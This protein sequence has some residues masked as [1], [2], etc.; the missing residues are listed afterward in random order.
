MSE[1]N[2]TEELP[3]GYFP[4]DLKLIQKHQ[5]LEPSILAKHKNGTYHK[6]Y[7]RGGS[8]IDVRLITC[9]YKIVIPSKIQRYLLHW[10]HMYLLYPVTERMEEMICQ[11][12]YWPNIRYAV[13]KDVTNCGTCQRTKR[14]IRKYDKLPSKLA[15]EI[16]LN[17]LCV[18]LVGPYLIG[19]KGKK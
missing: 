12:L 8:N 14:S 7:F 10:Y 4:I 16:S 13:R 11:H 18:Y 6:G 5:R 1:I 17:K 2:D 9:K 19:T 15:G 3:E